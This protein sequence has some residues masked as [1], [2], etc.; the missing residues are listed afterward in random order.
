MRGDCTTR[1]E[2]APFAGALPATPSQLYDFSGRPIFGPPSAHRANPPVRP[3]F[4]CRNAHPTTRPHTPLISFFIEHV[5]KGTVLVSTDAWEHRL[6]SRDGRARV[7]HLPS[8][9]ARR[10]RKSGARAQIDKRVLL[11]VSCVT[12]NMICIY[13]RTLQA[14]ENSK[15]IRTQNKLAKP[16]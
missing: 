14:M 16:N 3:R 7:D 11:L 2:P 6:I 1:R 5:K 15:Q 13:A 4:P 9:R 8:F 10:S 12:W